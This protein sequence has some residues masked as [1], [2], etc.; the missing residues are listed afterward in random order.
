M[1]EVTRNFSYTIAKIEILAFKCAAVGDV[2][3]GVILAY[4]CGLNESWALWL[5]TA[6]GTHDIRR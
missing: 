4:S 2:V 5:Q 1:P 3:H 6:S